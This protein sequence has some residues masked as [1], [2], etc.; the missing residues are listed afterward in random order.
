MKTSE[1]ARKA[2]EREEELKANMKEQIRKAMEE[3]V[4]SCLQSLSP[5]A[6]NISPD[7]CQLKRSCASTEVP[8]RQ[9]DA[10][11]RF[12]MDD[13]TA[14]LTS[15][16]LHIS[17]GNFTIKVATGVVSPIDPTKTARIHMVVVPPGYASVSVDR[18]VRGHENVPLD[19]E[20]GDWEKTI[21][22]A[23]KTLIYWKK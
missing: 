8:V 13:V 17:E 22:E 3:V 4:S 23:E 18:V 12:P 11:L 15:C 19:I 20:G 21:G 10:R 5:L 1:E 9:D 14:S 6:T 7:S 2:I 16:E